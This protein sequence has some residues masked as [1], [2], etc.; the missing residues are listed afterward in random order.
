MHI[1]PRRTVYIEEVPFYT[2]H[3]R[4]YIEDKYGADALYTEGLQVYTHVNVEMQKIA[5]QEIDIGLKDLD[6]R[7]GY[8]GPI[9]RLEP[10]QIETYC[11]ELEAKRTETPLEVGGI[12]EGVVIKVDDP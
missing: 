11:Q 7:Q 1:K 4:R 10:E 3:I 2:E 6:K 9:R 12:V 5:R 8:R